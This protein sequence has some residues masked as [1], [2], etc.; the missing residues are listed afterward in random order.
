M[1]RTIT[2]GTILAIVVF[3]IISCTTNDEMDSFDRFEDK[4]DVSFDVV[5]SKEGRIGTRGDNGYDN[6][7]Q[8]MTRKQNWT[9]ASLSDLWV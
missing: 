2:L 7:V 6:F 4:K 1:K 5:I 3:T 9:Q 8:K